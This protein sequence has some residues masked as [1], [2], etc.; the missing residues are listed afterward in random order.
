[1]PAPR[2][3]LTVGRWWYR[4]ARSVAR[5]MPWRLAV[6]AMLALFAAWHLLDTAPALNEFRDAHVLGHYE[7]AARDSILRWHQLPLWDPYYCGGM[8]LLGTPQA[9]FLSPTLLLTLLFGEP[10]GEALTA[11][12]MIIVGLEGAFRYARLRGATSL[13]AVLAAPVFAL[14]G[15]FAVAPALGWFN[16]FGFELLPWIALGARRA[17]RGDTRGVV[18]FAIAMAWCVGMGGTYAAP[19]AA[20][21][22]GFEA[23]EL[24]ANRARRR[25]WTALGWGLATGAAA[26]LL[27]AGLAAARLWPIADSLAAAPRII[28]GTP[29][30]K[31]EV[32]G[33]MLFS[34]LKTDT[35]DGTFFVGLLVL[36]A[37]LVGLWRRRSI[38]LA[39]AAALLVW[40]ALG[41]AQTPSLFAALRE[42]PLYTTLRYPERFLV[43][44]ALV[45]ATLAARGVSLLEAYV[46]TRGARSRRRRLFVAQALLVLAPLCLVF[47]LGPLTQQH[48]VRAGGRTLAAPPLPGAERPFHQARG[49]RW[50][51]EYY[52]PIQRGSLSCWEAY[53]VPESPLLRGDLQSEEQVQPPDA[54]TLTERSWSPNAIDLDVD[55]TKPA[56]VAVNQNWHSGW[57]AN[58]GEIH[59][60]RGL[61]TVAMPAGKQTLS[62]RFTPKSATGGAA[63]TL[64]ALAALALFMWRSRRPRAGRREALVLAGAALAP[65]LPAVAIGALVHEPRF[66]E[67]PIAMDGRPVIV[68]APGPGMTRLDARFDSGVVLEAASISSSSPGAGTDLVLELDWR[69]DVKLEKGLGIFMHI[70][71]SSGDGMNGDHVLLSSVLDLEDAP[72]DKTLRDVMPLWVPEDSRGKKW[73]VWV[74]LWRVR[75]GGERVKVTGPGQASIDQDRVLA[76]SYEVR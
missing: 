43:P 20:L 24:V 1:M 11:F 39:I 65:L 63:T 47:D 30:N 71:P 7:T 38:P 49:N 19:I 2:N 34:G 67:P 13:G 42:L 56:T 58:V 35:D 74:G 51:L 14:S 41:Y 55:L 17:L 37:V 45:L 25:R 40:L 9:R 33:G 16:F 66:V 12:V 23:V 8:Y 29:G 44:L 60:D 54:G 6:F 48:A 46:R 4:T 28:G 62:L 31:W 26:A 61:L 27:G 68:D 50:A 75:R 21:W 15:M 18:V 69:R 53:P 32:V 22:C 36:P 57:R 70:S 10:R 52:E 73:K 5:W 76:A 3:L 59:S 64:V 72:P